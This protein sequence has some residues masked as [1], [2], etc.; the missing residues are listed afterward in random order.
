MKVKEILELIDYV[1]GVVIEYIGH[2]DY[3]NL[4]E[5]GDALKVIIALYGEKYIRRIS[6]GNFNPLDDNTDDISLIVYDAAPEVTQ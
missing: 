2:M 1:D 4:G 3:Y 5:E 6:A